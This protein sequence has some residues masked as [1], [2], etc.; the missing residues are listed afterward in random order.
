MTFTRKTASLKPIEDTV[1][2]VVRAAKQDA[3]EMYRARS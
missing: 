2:T 3:A 1:F